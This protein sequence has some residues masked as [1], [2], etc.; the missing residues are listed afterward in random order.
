MANIGS[1]GDIQNLFKET[2]AEFMENGLE[3][4]MDD[5]P[6]YSKYGAKTR[7]QITVEMTQLQNAAH[8]L[9]RRRSIRAMRS[10]R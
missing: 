4:E 1:V 7:T 9:W 3:A 6:G 10:E 2:I 8:E 5:E